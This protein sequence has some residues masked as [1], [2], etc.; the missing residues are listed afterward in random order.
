MTD[1][2]QSQV[3]ASVGVKPDVKGRSLKSEAM[4]DEK[5]REQESAEMDKAKQFGELVNMFQ[6]NGLDESTNIGG[7]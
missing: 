4:I 2:E 5:N 7:I 3:L 6:E 1:A